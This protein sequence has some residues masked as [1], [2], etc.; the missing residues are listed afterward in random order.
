MA[1]A[2]A[3]G[4]LALLA[5]VGY[6]FFRPAGPPPVAPGAPVIPEGWLTEVA[7]LAASAVLG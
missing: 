5:L 7:I 4:I 2:A 1:V 3:L 6:I